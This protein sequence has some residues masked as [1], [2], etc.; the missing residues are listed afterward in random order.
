MMPNGATMLTS[1]D[2]SFAWP[3]ASAASTS[4]NSTAVARRHASAALPT[5]ET[6]N[7]NRTRPESSLKNS[8]GQRRTAPC[9]ARSTLQSA[10]SARSAGTKAVMGRPWSSRQETPSRRSIAAFKRRMFPF[11]SSTM[12]GSGRRSA[13]KVAIEGQSNH[14]SQG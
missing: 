3:T 1:Y 6:S 10:R 14:S 12:R 11:P 5:T 8:H 2:R 9:M 4:S 7:T 13:I